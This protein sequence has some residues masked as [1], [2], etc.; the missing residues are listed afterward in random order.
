MLT[1]DGEYDTDPAVAVSMWNTL[2]PIVAR[3]DVYK[4]EL[5]DADTLRTKL[6]NMEM[7][8]RDLQKSLKAKSDEISEMQIRKDKAEKRLMDSTKDN[9]LVSSFGK[10]KISN[11]LMALPPIHWPFPDYFFNENIF[12]FRF[13]TN[14]NER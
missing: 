8:I 14:S 11:K 4:A 7:D 5:K 9:E 13:V 12:D 6:K 1:Q 10:A 3:A 2:P